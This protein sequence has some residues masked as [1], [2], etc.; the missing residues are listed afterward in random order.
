MDWNNKGRPNMIE[1]WIVTLR[2]G[3]FIRWKDSK[4]KIYSNLEITDGG[5]KPTEK[6]CNDGLKAMQD[7]WDKDNT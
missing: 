5:Y 7:Q 3:D 2:G 6:E 4:N 1:D